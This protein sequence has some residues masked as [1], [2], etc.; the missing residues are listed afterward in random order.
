MS[1]FMRKETNHA[2]I[3]RIARGVQLRSLRL[4]LIGVADVIELRK[5]A[6]GAWQPFPVEHKRGKPKPDHS[7]NP[8]LRSG[9]LPG[10]DAGSFDSARSALLWQNQAKA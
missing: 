10:G 9:S 1:V 3:Y 4:G 7:D 6:K 2:E 5:T 8:A